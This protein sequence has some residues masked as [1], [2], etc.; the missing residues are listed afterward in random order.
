MWWNFIGRSHDEIEAYRREWQEQI[1]VDGSVV[2][3]G[4]SVADG[5]F[6]VVDLELAPIPAPE[7]PHVRLKLRQ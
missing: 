3:T 6:G 7:M 1:T 5:R 2:D 4:T